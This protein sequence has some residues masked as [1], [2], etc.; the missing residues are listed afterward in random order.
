M[1]AFI[2]TNKE[3]VEKTIKEFSS[4]TGLAA[5]YVDIDGKEVSDYY[6][7]TPFCQQIRKIPQLHLRCQ[8]CDKFGGLEASK[9]G[10]YCMYRCHAGLVDFAVPVKSQN[11]INGFILSGQ[12]HVD[13][14]VFNENM[15]ILNQEQSDLSCYKELAHAHSKVPSYSLT[16]IEAS[17]GLLH[18]ITDYYLTSVLDQQKE[19]AVSVLEG[20]VRET[21]HKKEIKQA[22][23][24]ISSHLNE[25]ISLEEVANHVYL[26]PFYFSKLFKKEMNET[27][28]SY[29]NT[30]KMQL[31]KEMLKNE[32]IPIS[33][34][35]RNLGYKET[36]YFCKVFKNHLNETPSHYRT[37]H[38]KN[39]YR[40]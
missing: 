19:S 37:K 17:A 29:V 21:Q 4:A 12:V 1:S 32:G 7:F 38:I 9:I 6:Q 33:T 40:I 18:V 25:P 3:Q 30:Q 34:I 13:D 28:V 35:A 27:F 26:S 23:K 5:I 8:L 24:Y 39:S 10:K 31:A 20:K 15:T 14:I 36:S 16:K 2:D 22:L 11:N